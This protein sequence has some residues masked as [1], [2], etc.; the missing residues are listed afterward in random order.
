MNAKE[1]AK[2]EC[3]HTVNGSLGPLFCN[4]EKGHS[5]LHRETVLLRNGPVDTDW[6][7]DG[8]A[9]WALRTDKWR[10]EEKRT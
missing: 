6:D 10:P 2:E 8:K 1:A 7:D 9:P 5:G 4:R 3:G